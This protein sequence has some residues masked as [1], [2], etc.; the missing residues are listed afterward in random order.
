MSID[1]S[2]HAKYQL[3]KRRISQKIVRETVESSQKVIASFRGRRL[4][5]KRV[6]GKL[7]EVV[8]KTEG[9]HVTII[10]GYYLKENL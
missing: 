9:S 8:T 6:R 1:F 5:Q 10:T 3:R 2:D 7:L 4:H